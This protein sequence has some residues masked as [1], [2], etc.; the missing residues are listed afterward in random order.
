MNASIEKVELVGGPCCGLFHN[1]DSDNMQEF[2]EVPYYAGIAIYRMQE[3]GKA[4]YVR[5]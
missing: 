2:M 3:N 1:V 5:G 4:R